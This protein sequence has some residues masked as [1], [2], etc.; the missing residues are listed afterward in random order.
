MMNGITIEVSR[1]QDYRA[2]CQ[3]LVTAFKDKFSALV[4]LSEAQ[5]IQLIEETWLAEFEANRQQHY[6]V[7]KQDAVVATFSVKDSQPRQQQKNQVKVSQLM[8][9]FGVKN[10]LSFSYGMS[11]LAYTPQKN[12][13]YIEHIAVSPIVQNQG[14]GKKILSFIDEFGKKEERFK[15]ISLHVSG[16]NERAKYLYEKN[17]FQVIETITG[18]KKNK[19]FQHGKWL[20]MSKKIRS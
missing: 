16:G 12:S 9:K 1:Q 4:T 14:V 2:I 7:K 15:T 6:V 11:L 10:L 5:T 13:W 19:I 8:K 18:K 3:L 17:G 20:F